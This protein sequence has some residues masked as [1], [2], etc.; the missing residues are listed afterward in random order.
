MAAILMPMDDFANYS[1]VQ[2]HT[3]CLTVE[4]LIAPIKELI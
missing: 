3:V 4:C 1:K 2:Q